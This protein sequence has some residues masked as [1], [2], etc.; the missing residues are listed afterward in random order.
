VELGFT[1]C[2]R[3]RV[4]VCPDDDDDEDKDNPFSPFKP[5]E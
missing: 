1:P 2:S 4:T 3:S 5:Q